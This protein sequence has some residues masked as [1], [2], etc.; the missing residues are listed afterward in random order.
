MAGCKTAVSVA[1]GE[2][3]EEEDGVG[4][5]RQGVVGAE[6]LAEEAPAEPG[7]VLRVGSRRNDSGVESF[8]EQAEVKAE[9][10]MGLRWHKRQGCGCG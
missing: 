3:L 7:V 2:E 1:L 4:D 8:P 6:G 5:G 9:F 10:I